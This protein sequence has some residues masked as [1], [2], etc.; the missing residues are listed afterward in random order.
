MFNCNKNVKLI[1]CEHKVI[2]MFLIK[3]FKYSIQYLI[4]NKNF[5]QVTSEKDL[6]N[7]LTIAQEKFGRLDVLVNAAGI[8][9][10]Y[11]TYNSQKKLPHVLEDFER[12]IKVNTIGS[13]NAIRLAAGVMCENQPNQDGQRGVIINTASVAAYDGQTGQAAYSASKGAIV[14][15]TLP[16]ARDL[17]R[18]GKWCMKINI[19]NFKYII[20]SSTMISTSSFRLYDKRFFFDQIVFQLLNYEFAK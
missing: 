18:D 10:A 11:K 15:M 14:G 4:K 12:V 16:I 7:A 1:I 20:L 19:L 5:T 6:Q 13:F 3:Y 9:V 8:A 17:S 2:V